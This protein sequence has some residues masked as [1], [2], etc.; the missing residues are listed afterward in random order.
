[1]K[2]SLNN[3]PKLRS[4]A[5]K[6]AVGVPGVIS[7]GFQGED[8]NQIVVTGD[9]IDSVN[10]TNLIRKGVGF[11]ELVS[12]S[13]VD[14]KDSNS[15]KDKETKVFAYPLGVPAPFYAYEYRDIGRDNSNCIIM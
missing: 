12:V 1:M 11:T 3:D 15:E 4:K 9:G 6:I 2:V 10:L 5:M 14:G 13:K 8:K 7:V